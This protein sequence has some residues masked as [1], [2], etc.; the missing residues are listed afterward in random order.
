MF[1]SYSPGKL[2][3]AGQAGV[4][5][6]DIPIAIILMNQPA[7]QIQRGDCP[8]GSQVNGRPGKKQ[9]FPAKFNSRQESER[10]DLVRI[11]LKIRNRLLAIFAVKCKP[12]LIKKVDAKTDVKSMFGGIVKP[13]TCTNDP[14]KNSAAGTKIKMDVLRFVEA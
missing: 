5:F 12:V 7:M 14:V 6:V 2:Q 11:M 9:P 10:A 4:Y 1:H 8:V 3:A 13:V